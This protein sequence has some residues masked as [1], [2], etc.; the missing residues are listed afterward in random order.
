MERMEAMHVEELS[1]SELTETSGASVLGYALGYCVG[2][3]AGLI[4]RAD[5]FDGNYYC[6]GA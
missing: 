2:Y 6:V 4:A 3:M 1:A 5:P